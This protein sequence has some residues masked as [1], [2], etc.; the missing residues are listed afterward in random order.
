MDGP[1][2]CFQKHVV[3]LFCLTLLCD[4][5]K[6]WGRDLI[7]IFHSIYL[8]SMSEMSLGRV[9][10]WQGHSLCCFHST[11]FLSPHIAPTGAT[12]DGNRQ[13]YVFSIPPQSYL[14]ELGWCETIALVVVVEEGC[15]CG[16]T[17]FFFPSTPKTLSPSAHAQC[18]I[19]MLGRNGLSDGRGIY[20]ARRSPSPS[21]LSNLCFISLDD[22]G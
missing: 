1:F 6:S 9:W 2:L 13:Q 4:M 19:L 7:H 16:A 21:P 12:N 3:L 17:Q 11:V 20:S 5:K 14:F 18:C 10:Q 22:V 8:Y 15:V